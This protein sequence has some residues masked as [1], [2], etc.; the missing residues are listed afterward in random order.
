MTM[1]RFKV[2]ATFVVTSHSELIYTH[3]FLSVTF[4]GCLH[5]RRYTYIYVITLYIILIRRGIHII[6]I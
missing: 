3:M 4:P 6:M 1:P 2:N 5:D